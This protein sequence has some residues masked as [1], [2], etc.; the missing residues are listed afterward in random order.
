[1][2]EL[3]KQSNH[4]RKLGFSGIRAAAAVIGVSGVFAL[5][6]LFGQGKIT[7]GA[8]G[9][10]RQ[11]ANTS[12][13]ADLDYS[14]VEE[15]YDALRASYDGRLSVED[16][17][18]GL[19]RGLVE[20]SGDPYTEFFDE[21][22]AREF[23]NELNGSFTGIG[24]ELGRENESIIIVAPISGFPAEKAGL[25]PR[26]VI[27]EVDGE[28]AYGWT[29][30]QAVSKIRGPE[31]TNVTLKVVR[32]GSEELTFEITRAQITIP[33]VTSEILDGNIGYLQIS[34]YSEDTSRLARTAAEDFKAASVKGVI[35]DLRSNPGGLLDSAVDVASLW[36]DNKTVLEEKR[37]DVVIKTFRSRGRP[38]LLGVPTAVL[39]NEGSASASEI[40]AGALKDHG[41]ATLIGVESFGKGSVQQVEELR[42]GGALKVT[43]ARW[44]TPHG[45]NLDKEGIKPDQS[46][47]FTEDDYKNNRDPQK[48]AAIKFLNQ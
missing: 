24:A 43:I 13:P 34:R 29:V 35:L 2:S 33:S 7:I 42:G 17:I 47:E 15:V 28:S 18:N 46:V 40:T 16:L 38:V 36:L 12:L 39:I 44:F 20:A 14:S 23:S 48:D 4:E 37:G 8:D 27:A 10:Y 32:G 45:V 41:A 26:D 25:R 9:V 1:M 5:G 31:N 3:D 22:A 6:V 21:E 30:Q 19:K 11:S